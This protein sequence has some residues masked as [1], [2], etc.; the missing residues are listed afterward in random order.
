LSQTQAAQSAST[1]IGA[2]RRFPTA[3]CLVHRMSIQ[4]TLLS[5]ILILVLA[6]FA[7]VG[8]TWL[9][10]DLEPVLSKK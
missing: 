4:S 8:P 2:S 10:D 7:L 3:A 1:F 5:H 6:D 9:L